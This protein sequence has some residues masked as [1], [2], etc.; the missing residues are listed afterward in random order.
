[1]APARLLTHVVLTALLAGLLVALATTPP[2]VAAESPGTITSGSVVWGLKDSWRRYIGDGSQAGDGAS[3]TAWK[4]STPVAFRFPVESGS[5]DPATR[6]TTLDLAGS[7]HFRSWYGQVQPGKWALDTRYSDLTLTISPTV[8]E[9]RGTHTGYTRDDPGGE[10]HHDV[11]VVLAQL[12][13]TDVEPTTTAGTT[14]WTDVPAVAGPGFSIY[15]QGTTLDP[16]SLEYAGDGGK[17][18]LSERLDRPGVPALREDGRW[19]SVSATSGLGTASRALEVS[20]KGDVVY[21]AEIAPEIGDTL[22]V[23]ALDAHTMEP[24][25]RPFEQPLAPEAVHTGRYLRTAIDPATDTLFYV[26]SRDGDPAVQTTVRS[27]TFDRGSG[28]FTSSVVG[29]LHDG[30]TDEDGTM[31]APG[32]GSLT[33]NPVTHELAVLSDDLAATD[34]AGKVTLFRFSRQGDGWTRAAGTVTL[35]TAG[36]YAGAVEYGGPFTSGEMDTDPDLAPLGDGSYVLATGTGYGYVDDEV[37]YL[38][39]LHLRPSDDTVDVTPVPGT[40]H[41][42]TVFGTYYG[43]TSATP[44][45][46]GSVLLH[47]TGQSIEDYVRVDLVDGVATARTPVRGPDVYPDHGYSVLAASMVYDAGRD[48]LWATDNANADGEGLQLVRPDGSTVGYR[49]PDY[50]TYSF[51]RALLKVGPDG[52]LYVPVKKD[53]FGYARLA[54]GG[55][56][57]TVVQQPKDVAVQLAAGEAERDVSLRADVSAGSSLQ[58]Q[59]RPAGASRFTDVKG[60][61]G[62]SLTVAAS[63]ST[64]GS[65]YRLMVTN[66]AGRVVSDEARLTVTYPPRFTVQ[67]RDVRTRPGTVANLN[68]EVVASPDVTSST[69]QRRVNGFWTNV[70]TDDDDLVV[71]DSSLMVRETSTDQD[72]SQFRLKVTSPLGTA[73][74]QTATLT[75][76]APEP[77]AGTISGATLEWSGSQELQKAPPFGGS[78]YFS[79]GVSDG[80]EKTYRATA[81]NVSV[82]QADGEKRTAASWAT[83]AAHVDSDPSTRQLVTLGG[84]RGRVAKDGSATISWSGAWTV[85]FYGGLVPFTLRDPV[86]TVDDKGAGRLTADL[87]GYGSS[88]EN[89][90]E[91]TPVAPVED[92]VVATY[93]DVEVDPDGFVVEPDY[94]GVQVDVPEGASAQLRR[95]ESWG[96]WPQPFVDFHAR[97]GLTSYWY[98]SGGAAD[99]DKPPAPFTVSAF[100]VAGT[101]PVPARP[102]ILTQPS[103]MTATVGRSARFSVTASGSDPSYQWQRRVGSSWLAVADADGPTLTLARVVK[104]DRRAAFRVRVSNPSGAVLSRAVRLDVAPARTAARVS[105]SRASQTSRAPASRRALVRVRVTASN[106]AT[107]AGKVV[108]R[109]GGRKVA[110][111]RAHGGRATV[112]LPAGL[113]RRSYA[114]RVTF[115]PRD[116]ASFTKSTSRPVRFRV[117]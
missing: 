47:G 58:W 74:S 86:L 107:P 34:P 94:A 40:R 32:V 88:Q 64:A 2:A 55:V 57:P 69:W 1:M 105:L 49:V 48:L 24:V 116:T 65:T 42:S 56:T 72:G 103:S 112:R 62:A 111:A 7:V 109:L 84:G 100:D 50:A 63:P 87:S 3:V 83:R 117:R 80:T 73:Y 113:A 102:T 110:T 18:D 46:D 8:Q 92:V 89:P 36:E 104:G 68:A 41:T 21:V 53:G 61:T 16:V 106:G 85:N 4:G 51:G 13:V 30:R 52:S 91:K 108:V 78:S 33:W 99:P 17:P 10:L 22:V 35:P 60:A 96:S 70:G 6:T 81:G 66:D 90:G 114:V 82:L 20:P 11:D 5:Y 19:M 14:T 15:G 25:G 97:T 29:R 95:G 44:G 37:R 28:S 115:V 59:Q 45:P 71:G 79:A 43:Y 101:V 26:T 9:I 39:A 77:A 93:R 76:E 98:S 38:P 54:F 12:D 75:V 23:R 67:P 31:Q 27:L